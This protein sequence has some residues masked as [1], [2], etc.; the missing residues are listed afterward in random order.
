MSAKNVKT[1]RAAH[2]SWNK[3]DFAGVVS[4]AVKAA[5]VVDHSHRF[6]PN[7]NLNWHPQHFAV[8]ITGPR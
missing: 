7:F 1:L 5:A 8:S 2:Q 3:R 6:M 4:K